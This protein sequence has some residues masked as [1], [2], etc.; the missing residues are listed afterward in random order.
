MQTLDFDGP[1]KLYN[2]LNSATPLVFISGNVNT[3]RRI[4]C[5]VHMHERS[6]PSTACMHTTVQ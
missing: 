1:A 5:V 4:A 6:S 3:E 2:V